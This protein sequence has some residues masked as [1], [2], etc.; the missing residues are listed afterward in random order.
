MLRNILIQVVFFIAIFMALSW[1]KSSS[2]LSTSQKLPDDLV[3]SISLAG[4]QVSLKSEGKVKVLYF[5][6]PWCT[7]CH[8]SIGNVQGL[9]EKNPNI[10]VVAIA[11][12]YSSNKAVTDFVSQ[13]E[14]TIPIV[15]GNEQLKQVFKIEAYPSYYVIDANNE[16]SW[17]S[18]GY[19]TELGM[20]LATKTS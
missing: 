3:S 5:F 16:I 6:A 13:H 8:V 15:Y 12:D 11:L 17:R 2:M 9:Y 20:Y 19:S 18:V 7:V 4:E 1:F 10:D 14:L